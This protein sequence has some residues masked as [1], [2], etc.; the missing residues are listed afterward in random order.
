VFI[1]SP[2]LFLAQGAMSMVKSMRVKPG[3]NPVNSIIIVVDSD[4]PE[5]FGSIAVRNK[6]LIFARQNGLPDAKGLGG[7]PTHYPVDSEGKTDEDLILGKRK[8]S[9]HQA[10]YVVNAGM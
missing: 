7:I 10:E 4:N 8:F 2:A 6:V 1:F 5:D 9:H 3:Q